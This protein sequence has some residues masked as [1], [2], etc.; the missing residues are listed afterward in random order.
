VASGSVT[1]RWHTIERSHVR[2]VDVRM[3]KGDW[4]RTVRSDCGVSSGPFDSA[5]YG[6]RRRR[7]Q[8]E[9]IATVLLKDGTCYGVRVTPVVS[10]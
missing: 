1:A 6:V 5:A 7:V 8:C 10:S 9:A 4:F 3:G 2:I